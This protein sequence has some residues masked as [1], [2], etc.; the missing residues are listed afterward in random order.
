MGH[1]DDLING[2]DPE[3]ELPENFL[4]EI[5]NAYLQDISIPE[6]KIGTLTTQLTEKDNA[7]SLASAEIQR[8]KSTNFDLLMKTGGDISFGPETP[9]DGDETTDVD[10]SDFFKYK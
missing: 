10:F 1:F 8:V 9:H 5:K 6:A 3:G 7:L 2:I 4:S